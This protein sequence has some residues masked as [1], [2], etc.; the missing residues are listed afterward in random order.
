MLSLE[1]IRRDVD[2][3]VCKNVLLHFNED[4]RISVIKMFHGAMNDGGFFAMEQTQKLPGGVESLFTPI[5]TNSQLFQK[6]KNIN[7]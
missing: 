7:K 3:I 2:L 6:A 4:E 1:P 5:A